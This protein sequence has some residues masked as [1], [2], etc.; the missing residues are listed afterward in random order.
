MHPDV[1]FVNATEGGI[2]KENTVRMSLREAL[3]RYCRRKLPVSRDIHAIFAE[4]DRTRSSDSRALIELKQECEQMRELVRQ[5]QGI[6]RQNDA[7]GSIGA[8]KRLEA[9]K[10]GIYANA[11]VAGIVDAFNQM[12]N[13]TFLRKMNSVKMSSIDAASIPEIIKVYSEYLDSVMQA[14]D[15]ISSALGR[16]DARLAL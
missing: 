5:G 2:L 15:K 12:G 10:A 14:T 7:Q 11:R 6:C 3:Y 1:Q 13:V 8:V 16:I 9:V 4:V